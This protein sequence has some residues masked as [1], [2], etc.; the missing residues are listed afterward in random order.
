LPSEDV[1]VELRTDLDAARAGNG[2]ALGRVLELCRPYLLAIANADLDSDLQ[3]KA[4]ASDL[5]QQ[6]LMEA[7]QAFERFAGQS[8]DELLAWL[9]RIL[10]NNLVD[11]FRRF[12][13]APARNLDR[14]ASLDHEGAD[15]LRQQIPSEA[16]SPLDNLVAV[17]KKVALEEALARLPE[18]YRRVIDLRH[19]EGKSFPEI[20]AALGKTDEAV[21]KIWFRALERLRQEL[22]G[23]EEFGSTS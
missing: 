8:Q 21:R 20:G 11:F 23:R 3:A 1:T 18:E 22:E 13:D 14:E 17:E 10:K 19:R 15:G 4:G 16:S 12:R 9:K 6:S 2:S 7:Q 5:V